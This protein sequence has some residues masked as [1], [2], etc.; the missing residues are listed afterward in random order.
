M[1]RAIL[2]GVIGH[3]VGYMGTGY[4]W[5]EYLRACPGG[6]DIGFGTNCSQHSMTVIGMKGEG[7]GFCLRH[8]SMLLSNLESSDGQEPMVS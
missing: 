1:R 2:R 7:W 4:I 6:S 3:Y 5:T 8:Y